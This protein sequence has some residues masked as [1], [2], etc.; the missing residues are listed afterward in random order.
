LISREF[1]DLFTINQQFLDAQT[2]EYYFLRNGS[3]LANKDFAPGEPYNLN[4]VEAGCLLI[5]A[6]NI[7]LG[8]LDGSCHFPDG[9]WQSFCEVNS[10]GELFDKIT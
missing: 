3:T 7:D 6:G 8:L 10:T 4:G 1:K 2:R 9:N 5:I